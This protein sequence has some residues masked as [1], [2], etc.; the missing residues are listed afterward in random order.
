MRRF[1][2]TDAVTADYIT[3]HQLHFRHHFAQTVSFLVVYA[4]A[5]AGLLGLGGWLVIQ[6]Q[7]SLGQLVAAEVVLSV[8]FFGVTQLG[9]YLGVFLRALRR[10]RRTRTLL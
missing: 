1:I 4:L 9:I 7:L 10:T 6:G 8:A 5:S 3:H 2:R